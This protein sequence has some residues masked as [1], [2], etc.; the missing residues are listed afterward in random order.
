MW[1]HFPSLVH[2]TL[3]IEQYD[4]PHL[5]RECVQNR[6]HQTD[7]VHPPLQGVRLLQ[8]VISHV[9]KRSTAFIGLIVWTV[10]SLEAV[11]TLRV[12]TAYS[13]RS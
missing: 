9:E 4:V 13:A 12:T 6:R 3:V 1:A 7:C 10:V 11:D 5:S 2:I 8:T